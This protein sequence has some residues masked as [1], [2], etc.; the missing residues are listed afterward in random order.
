MWEIKLFKVFGF[1]IKLIAA[2][3]KSIRSHW[4]ASQDT[5]FRSLWGHMGFPSKISILDEALF[6]RRN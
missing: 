3:Q 1:W 5:Q 6:G 2:M 4:M